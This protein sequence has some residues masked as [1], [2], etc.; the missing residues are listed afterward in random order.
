MGP[1]ASLDAV[2]KKKFLPLWE[3]A[4]I[5]TAER[6]IEILGTT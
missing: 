5:K 3:S 2:E 4:F 6:L 1:R